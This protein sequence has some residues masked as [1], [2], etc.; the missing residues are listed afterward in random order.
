MVIMQWLEPKT[1]VVSRLLVMVAFGT[2]LAGLAGTA[3]AE[4]S[5]MVFDKLPLGPL[6]ASTGWQHQTVGD[7]TPNKAKIAGEG[8]DRFIVIESDES[9]SAWSFQLSNELSGSAALS[10]QWLIQGKPNRSGLNE[11]SRD[12]FAARVYVIFDYPLDKLSFGQRL[13]IRLARS[14]YGDVPAAAICYVWLPGG[15]MDRLA[16]S[17]YTDRVKM[18]VAGNAPPEA[19]WQQVTRNL[20]ADFERAFGKEYGPGMPGLKAIVVSS[21]TDQ[22]GGQVRASFARMRLSKN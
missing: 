14:I 20:K 19:G 8:Q 21:D 11:K 13:G 3:R 12:D 16:D 7:I 10:W 4:T 18:I 1:A 6:P 2:L 22:S 17:P 15:Q 5:L 9:A